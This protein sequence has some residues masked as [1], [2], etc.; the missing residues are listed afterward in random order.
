M[1]RLARTLGR[2]EGQVSETQ[3]SKLHGEIMQLQ[4]KVY[5]CISP[6]LC[7]EVSQSIE[8]QIKKDSLLVFT[9]LYLDFTY[10]LALS[11]NF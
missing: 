3:W 7:H 9:D 6:A 5:K 4:D 8:S 11:P 1:I 10:S 2:H